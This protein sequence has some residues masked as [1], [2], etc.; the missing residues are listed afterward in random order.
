MDLLFL[1]SVPIKVLM[2]NNIYDDIKIVLIFIKDNRCNSSVGKRLKWQ[3]DK[4]EKWNRFIVTKCN[5]I[6]G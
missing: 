4:M 3:F 1:K 2:Y 6:T 5:A